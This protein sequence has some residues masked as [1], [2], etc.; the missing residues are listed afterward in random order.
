[1]RPLVAAWLLTA[2]LTAHAQVDDYLNKTPR[3]N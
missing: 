3:F 1:M 2:A